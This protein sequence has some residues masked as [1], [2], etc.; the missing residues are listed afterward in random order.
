[1]RGGRVGPEGGRQE[2]RDALYTL[3][4]MA[5]AIGVMNG[6][7]GLP[8]SDP[9]TLRGVPGHRTHQADDEQPTAGAEQRTAPARPRECGPGA[10]R[11]H[12][13]RR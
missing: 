7:S 12:P 6:S 1:M 4:P 9:G 5:E 10:G 13:V 8:W 3:G 11:P 2:E